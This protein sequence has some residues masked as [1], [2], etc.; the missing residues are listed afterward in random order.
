[1]ALTEIIL[2]VG[3]S[4]ADFFSSEVSSNQVKQALVKC[5][6]PEI[7]SSFDLVGFDFKVTTNY[8]LCLFC[9]VKNFW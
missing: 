5:Q 3:C 6:W 2:F 9:D 7:T 8:L 4:I 1:M